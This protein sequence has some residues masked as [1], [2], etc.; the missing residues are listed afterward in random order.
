MYEN[1][2]GRLPVVD[3][4]DPSKIIGIISKHDILKAFEM[5]AQRS[6]SQEFIE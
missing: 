2:V 3:R 5:A 6:A 4:S 1:R